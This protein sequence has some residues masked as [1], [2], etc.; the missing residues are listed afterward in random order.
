VSSIAAAGYGAASAGYDN[1]ASAAA[2]GYE[3]AASVAAAGYDAA[4][5]GY[6]NVASAA[7]AGYENV[8]SA[9]GAAG[10]NMSQNWDSLVSQ[11]S[12]RVYG[13]PTPTPWYESMYSVLGDYASSATDGAVSATS[14]AAV[15]AAAASDQAGQQY[16]VVSSIISELV[17]GK[18]PSFTE[19]VYSR[20]N[21]AYVTGVASASSLASV[22]QESAASAGEK[23][24]SVASGATEVVA[25]AASEATEAVKES[26]QH[27]RDEL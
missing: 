16:H 11:L 19:S 27:V 21:A 22:A 17:V 20:L 3:S 24:A 26:V 13:A 7:G 15:Y 23:V 18:E 9:A 6:E 5:A 12:V 4:A 2:A 10:D 25:S 8:A 14:T 1:A